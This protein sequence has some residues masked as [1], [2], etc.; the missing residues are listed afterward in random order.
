MTGNPDIGGF[1]FNSRDVTDRVVA[2]EEI[3]KLSLVARETSNAIIITNPAG[4]LLWVNDAFTRM[5]EFK[6][7]E[8]QGKKP[9]QFLQG[10]DT[11]AATIRYMHRKLEQGLPFECDIINYTKSR[12]PY[13]LRLQCQP[14]FDQHGKLES[15]F[16][17]QT[18]I[19]HEKETEIILKKSEEQYR[20]LF[21]NNP[22]AILIW[23]LESLEILEANETAEKLYGYSRKE[24]IGKPVLD[25]CLEEEYEKLK[26]F[27]H[28]AKKQPSFKAVI[29]CKRLNK[30][31]ELMHMNIS[32][33]RIEYNGRS[34][35]LAMGNNVT[36]K[37]ELEKMLEDE[38]HA[39]QKE[40]TEAVISAQEFERHELGRELHDNINQIL[41]S[42]LLYLGLAKS[43]VMGDHPFID[44]AD[45]LIQS[46]INE[47]RTLSHSLI[48]P[49]LND[50]ELLEALS[51]VL[52]NARV[53]GA[54]QI[55]LASESFDE[56]KVPDNL[57][58]TIFRMVQEQL[59]NILKHA[60]ATYVKVSLTL[61][62]N[63]LQ[64]SIKDNGIGFNIAKKSPG[65]GLMNIRTRAALFNAKFCIQSSPGEGCELTVI[66]AVAQADM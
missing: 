21:Q 4:E 14:Q 56:Q 43:N 10:P 49:S 39:R 27:A 51:K 45:Q 6:L 57:K 64:L 60:A 24:F 28:R 18:D 7:Y 8:V 61:Q 1:V 29:T 26:E 17:V 42:S 48:P 52:E 19:S 15:F 2:A 62:D 12:R 50:S 36:D 58:L 25:L 22:A 63:Q 44:K 35:V 59:N 30:K 11:N 33:H 9:G 5:T 37:L 13:W 53:S 38:R 47:V 3:K 66:F 54:L 34:V 16:S 40:I 31:R 20:Y 41:A 46:A 32:F 65:V 23:D 55:D